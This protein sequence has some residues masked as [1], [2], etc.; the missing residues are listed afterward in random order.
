MSFPFGPV[1]GDQHNTVV[2][3]D[4]VPDQKTSPVAAWRYLEGRRRIITDSW[5]QRPLIRLWDKNM[6]YVATISQEVSVN[7]EE[8]M[9][10]SGKGEIVIRRNNWLSNFILYD[11]RAEEDLHIT[12]DPNPLNRNW[13]TRWGGKV[14]NVRAKRDAEGLHTVT[15]ECT[16]MREHV[17][18]IL[19]IANPVFPPEL[20]PLRMYVTPGNTRTVVSLAFAINLARQYFP[21]LAVIDNIFNPTYWLT[22]RLGNFNPLNWPIQVAFVNPLTDQSRTTVFASRDSDMHTATA[23]IL[24]D[25]GCMIRAYT[26]LEEDEDSPHT[27]LGEFGELLRPTR[28]CII[29][30]V[31][32]KSG[33]TGPTGTAFD[34]FLN[35]IAATADDFITE[36]LFNLD[37]DGDG[38]T[39]P[40]FRKLLGVAPKPPWVVF[41]DDEHS[42]IIE[43]ERAVHASTAR[44]IHA[45]GRSPQWLN[46][47]QTFGIKYLLSQL[48]AVISYGL[49]A[50]QQPGTPGLEELY[51]GQLDNTLFSMMRFTDLKRALLSGEFAFLEHKERG[52]GV[53]YTLAGVLDLRT[54]AWKTRAYTSFKVSIRNGAPYVL[55]EDFTLGD[56]LAFEMARVLHVDQCTAWRLSY[57]I[58]TP[59]QVE[60]SIGADSEEEDPVGR[61]LRVAQAAW[62]FIGMLMGS[63]GAF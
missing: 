53:A 34:G 55:G 57:D 29:L 22:A 1:N 51:Q 27:E 62:A 14:I 12:V 6:Q 61:A 59:L 39:D 19:A 38:Q 49:G 8:L 3:L 11:R 2:G 58:N 21:P 10:D 32:D 23:A 45:G 33:V 46:Q 60:L 30:A 48:S 36:T 35:L 4:G 26:W 50:Y 13:R 31:E 15:L 28:N 63:E 37:Q 47:L 41:R 42:G 17:K 40:F 9:K 56:R 25:A 24:E 5:R 54:G 43:S 18:H 7:V 44:T 16:T 52:S 20:Q